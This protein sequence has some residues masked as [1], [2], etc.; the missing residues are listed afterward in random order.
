LDE[1]ASLMRE[2][3]LTVC[4]NTGPMHLAVAVGS[5]TLAFF[6]HIELERWAHARPPHRM[7]DLTRHVQRGEDVRRLAAEETRALVAAT[8]EHGAIARPA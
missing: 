7:V 4:N 5:P 8:Q 3:R 2:A 1:L 6:F